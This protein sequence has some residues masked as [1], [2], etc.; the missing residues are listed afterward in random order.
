MI[1]GNKERVDISATNEAA[2]IN[3]GVGAGASNGAGDDILQMLAKD[4]LKDKRARRRWGLFFRCLIVAG[5]II[6]LGSKFADTLV[7]DAHTAVVEINGVIGPG[8]VS[9]HAINRSLQDAFAAPSSQAVIIEINSPGGTPVQA[10][11]INAEIVRLRGLYPAKPVYACIIDIGAS[12]GYYI[13]VAADEIYAHPASIVGSIGVI[14]NGFGLSGVLQKLGIERRLITAGKHKGI[15]DPFSPVTPFDRTHAKSLLTD[16]H[17]EFIAAVKQGRGDRLSDHPD[18]FTGLFW[19]G[20]QAHELG[21]IDEFGST[22]FIA[23]EIVGEE[24]LVDYTYELGFVE[25][26]A[27]KIGATLINTLDNTIFAKSFE[28]R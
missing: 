5:L 22:Q 6:W 16:V 17:A 18:I 1:F 19:S 14:M 25:G 21:L 4:Y 20:K 10:A 15:L 24:T 9:A 2:A 8:A 28:L 27:D 11:Q 13:A 12:G 23:R 3:N 7:D 26:L